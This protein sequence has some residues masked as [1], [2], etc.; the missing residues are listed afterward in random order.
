RQA[1]IHFTPKALFQHQTVQ[2]LATVAS[3]GASGLAVDQ[4]RVEGAS[5]LLPIHRV[6]FDEV[7][8]ERHHW[9]QSVLLKPHQLL[10]GA[11]LEQALQALLEQHD[12]LRLG[13]VENH[14][15][16]QAT[17]H[18]LPNHSVLWQREIADAEA[19]EQLGQQ[20]QR[21]LDLNHG[22]L[23]RAVLATLGNGEQR[24]LL[25]IHHLAVDGVSWRIIFED[26]QQAYEQLREGQAVQLP[27]R[28]H[29]VRDWAQRLQA[30]ALSIEVQA[31]RSY[32]QAQ[33]AGVQTALPGARADA[34]LANRHARSVHSRLSPELT[35]R[36]LQEAPAAYRTQV[37]DL[38]LSALARVIGRWSGQADTLIQLEGHGREELFDDLDLTRTVGW[39]TSLFPLRISA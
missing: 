18:G 27:A 32:W 13:F 16:W 31:Q 12:A 1:G 5:T 21:S 23:L 37:N 17:Y 29:S 22:P 19:L 34:S 24:L 2:G 8:V 25:V 26:L 6:F 14:G 35:R 39:F 20:A 36:L 9:N 30:Y 11:V 7:Q 4:N 3:L 33:L 10:D 28:T 38:L 15:E